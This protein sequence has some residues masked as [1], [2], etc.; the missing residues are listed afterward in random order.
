[1][2]ARVARTR[3]V[4]VLLARYE[5]ICFTSDSKIHWPSINDKLTRTRGGEG[6]RDHPLGGRFLDDRFALDN[7]QQ[8][9]PTGLRHFFEMPTNQEMAKISFITNS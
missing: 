1:M 4:C 5:G 8:I 2:V 9:S 3:R 7:D 6:A